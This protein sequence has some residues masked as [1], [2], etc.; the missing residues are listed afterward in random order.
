M[1]LTPESKSVLDT[2]LTGGTL[3]AAN[4]S[5]GPLDENTQLL[6]QVLI[7]NYDALC[8]TRGAQQAEALL[9]AYLGRVEQETEETTSNSE[10]SQPQSQNCT[11]STKETHDSDTSPDVPTIPSFDTP[12]GWRLHELKCRSI[13]GV[14]PAGE[15][16]TFSFDGK[17]NLLFGP[18]GSGKSSLLGAVMW[19]LTSLTLTDDPEQKDMSSIYKTSEGAKRGSKILDW[20]PISTLPDTNDPS[21]CA[22]DSMASIQLKSSDNNTTL[23][24][25]RRIYQ[26]LEISLDDQAWKP[27]HDLSKYG[28]KSLDLQ[29]SIIAPTIF[30]RKAIETAPNSRKILSLMLGY[31]PLEAIGDLVTKLARNRTSFF[32]TI[33]SRVNTERTILSTKIDSLTN[34]LTDESTLKEPLKALQSLKK[35]SSTKIRETKGKVSD[36]I[37]K[38][39]SSLVKIL[40]IADG[41]S[42]VPTEL[43]ENLIKA[44]GHLEKGFSEVFPSLSSIAVETMLP[45]KDG[46]SPEERLHYIE[47]SLQS[48]VGS[49]QTKIEERLRWWRKETKPG[50]K[51]KLL[52]MAAQSYDLAKIECPVCDQSIK[53]LPVK[54]ELESLKDLDP[55]LIEELKLFFINLADDLNNTVRENIRIISSTSPHE[56]IL[57]DWEALEKRE[58]LA[59]L[60]QIIKDFENP[61]NQLT[62][63]I[64]M[65]TTKLPQLL[66]SDAEPLF[67]QAASSLISKVNCAYM[68]LAILR[69]SNTKLTSLRQKLSYLITANSTENPNSLLSVLSK[70]KT[71]AQEIGPLKTLQTQLDEIATA[72]DDILKNQSKLDT[73]KNLKE[74]L[75]NSKDLSKY[76]VNKTTTIFYEIKD[77]AI[78]NWNLLYPEKSTGLYPSSLVMAGGRDKSI[79]SLL[80]YGDYEVPGPPFANAGLQRA[81]ALSFLCAM[82]EKHPNGLGF[83]VFDDPILSLDEDHRE[84]WSGRILSRIMETTQVILATHQRQ[85]LTNCKHDFASGKV[86]ELNP[87]DRKC[88]ISWLPGDSLDQSEELLEKNW[89]CVPNVLR[90]YCE[91]MLIT[92]QAYS[93]EDFFNPHNLE[94]SIQRYKNLTQSNPL[95]GTQQ[96]Q[97]SAELTKP[98]IERVLNPGSHA[99][100]Q[101]DITKPM[102]EDCLRKLRKPI[103]TTFLSELRRLR[104]RRSRELRGSIIPISTVSF[105]GEHQTATFNRPFTLP[106]IGRAAARPESW[107]LDSSTE[108]ALTKFAPSAAIFVSS[109]TLNPVIR[110][111]QCALLA[112][113]E[114][115]LEDDNL[116]AVVSSDGDRYLR[117]LWSESEVYILQAIHPTKPVPAIRTLKSQNAI[118]KV[119]GVLYEPA[120]RPNIQKST[121]T[122]EW[123]PYSSFP[124]KI[125]SNLRMLIVE[126][127]SLDP[128]ARKGQKVLVAE[129]ETP[130]NTSLEQGGLAALE[131]EDEAIGN[132]IKQIY[133]KSDHWILVSPNPILAYTPDIIPIEK[134]KHIWPLC[135]VLFETIDQEV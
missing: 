12:P 120:L 80:T 79:E 4:I 45:E 113:E 37:S 98:E 65:I 75:D 88:R 52:L 60:S 106:V 64:E 74:P 127:D 114:I 119:I 16:F 115:Q 73:L 49:A 2:L 13:K 30:G 118:R 70:G 8:A 78:N 135:G 109:N 129:P 32:N 41:D 91:D 26:E 111:G 122:S 116:V 68:T 36:Q 100:T 130:Q 39:N 3:T 38:S 28:I 53:D 90:Q 72:N 42:P 76:A 71:A 107:V 55:E 15:E 59:E 94:N 134:I 56:R 121:K 62:K 83:V 96:K 54:D 128:I 40:G 20:P 84:R 123:Y 85:F 11:E 102:V 101:D 46:R 126:G 125:F 58:E 35:I 34:L 95:V 99:L 89:K 50:S 10:P 14:A 105:S 9:T 81:I 6:L 27:C 97:I 31:D 22:P 67:L 117:K 110:Y 1:R 7:D 69:W 77:K 103:S 112:D 19:I 66:P 131:I 87:R 18:N 86:V 93:P 43:G 24:L 21:S 51:A 47:E 17:S 104:E 132:V 48:F 61:V 133:R 25:R 63:S 92:L 82:F 44:I 124:S 108:V 23:Y 5:I 57:S 33:T 29:L